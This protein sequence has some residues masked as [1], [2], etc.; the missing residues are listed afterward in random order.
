VAHRG[1]HEGIPENTLPAYQRAI[2][3]GCDFVE[4][5][6]RTTKDGKIVSMHNA[7]LSAYTKG[8]MKDK[9]RDLTLDQIRAIDIG[10]RIAPEFK[11]VKV[12]TFDEIL[13]LCKGKIGIY[14]DLKDA[15]IK[16]LADAI[17][18]RGMEKNVIW[19]VTAEEAKQMQTIC[20]ECIPMPDPGPIENL[21]KLLQEVKPKVVATAREYFSADFAD[22][23]HK[24]GAIVIMDEAGPNSWAPSLEWNVDGIQTDQPAKL[25]DYLKARAAKAGK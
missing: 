7:D 24:A 13:D 9:V 23:C 6:T 17:K 12:P 3:L 10:S 18:A 25:I 11:D 1:A 22:Q 21:P 20:P 19:Y 5:D 2:D 15:D 4:I 14:L 8:A 16:T